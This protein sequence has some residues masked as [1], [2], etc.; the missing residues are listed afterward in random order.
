M[1]VDNAVEVDFELKTSRL[2]SS[3]QG[4]EEKVQE[5]VELTTGETVGGRNVT[6]KRD[7]GRRGV[8]VVRGKRANHMVHVGGRK[9]PGKSKSVKIFQKVWKEDGVNP[10]LAKTARIGIDKLEDRNRD[11]V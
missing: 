9:L 11:R 6:S 10:F 7:V 3:Q 8:N 4:L 5:G 1:T 2:G